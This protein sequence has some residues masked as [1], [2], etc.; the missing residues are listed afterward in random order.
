MNT[1][2]KC[3]TVLGSAL[4]LG[5]LAGS[6]FFGGPLL[7]GGLLFLLLALRFGFR[8]A[9]L[10]FGLALLQKQFFL[11]RL[12]ASFLRHFERLHQAVGKGWLHRKR[13][14]EHRQRHGRE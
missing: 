4:L 14:R 9:L 2:L 13:H 5:C 3:K 7:F 1:L 6:L 11:G 8:R 10:L 12:A